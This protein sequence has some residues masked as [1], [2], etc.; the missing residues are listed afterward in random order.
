MGFRTDLPITTDLIVVSA[1]VHNIAVR[2]N[3]PLIMDGLPD[4]RDL[5][6]NPERAVQREALDEVQAEAPH[7]NGIQRANQN[8]I[9]AQGQAYRDRIVENYF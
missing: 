2:R 7:R 9:R 6:E 5:P 3:E 8:I 1:M 4:L